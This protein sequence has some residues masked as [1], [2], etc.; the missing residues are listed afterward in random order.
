MEEKSK[1]FI[2][3]GTFEI[4]I[5]IPARDREEAKAYSEQRY[6]ELISKRLAE[7]I[8]ELNDAKTV[9]VNLKKLNRIR[10]EGEQEEPEQVEEQ[11]K[12]EGG[13]V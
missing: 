3:G 6:E 9:E 7:L 5:S 2:V 13:L 10:A 4:K 8:L 11:P 1:R 12:T